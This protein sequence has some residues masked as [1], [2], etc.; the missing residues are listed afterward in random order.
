MKTAILMVMMLFTGF[1]SSAQLR[2]VVVDANTLAKISYVNIWVENENIGTTSNESGEFE[3]NITDTNKVIV[4]SAIGYSTTKMRVS[5]IDKEVTLMPQATVL[6]EVFIHPKKDTRTLGIGQFKKSGIDFYYVSGIT[7][8]MMA[9]YFA[10][11]DE[12]DQTPYLKKIRLLTQS[13]IKNATFNIRLFIPNKNGEP[14]DYLYGKNIIG[15]AK[16]GNNVT[17]VDLSQLNIQFPREGFFI[18]MEWLIIE[19]NKYE[20]TYT[21]AGSKEK[22]K[23]I[24]YEP[25]I[26]SLP[27]NK[28]NNSWRYIEGN[29]VR[30][31]NS[32]PKGS[33]VEYRHL[34]MELTLTN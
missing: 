8:W 26:G 22:F 25:F 12:Y 33:A 3:L 18:A 30:L 16:K 23:G 17:E 11:E 9:N 14:G 7:P 19:S 1:L 27:G 31:A 2:A 5:N 29:W 10:Y 6:Q 34:T 21:R 13:K 20:Y 4:F 15:E 28:E 32:N 24:R